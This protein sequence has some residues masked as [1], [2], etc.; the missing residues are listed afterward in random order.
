MARTAKPAPDT[1][2][3]HDAAKDALRAA[4]ALAREML[5]AARGDARCGAMLA[6]ARGAVEHGSKL[7]LEI[8]FGAQSRIV[9]AVVDP[10]GTRVPIAS[11]QIITPDAPMH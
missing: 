1:H 7:A 11:L 9:L 2:E 6:K 3:Q 10:R 4:Q 8:E 5:D